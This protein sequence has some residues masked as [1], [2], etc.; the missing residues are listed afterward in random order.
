MVEIFVT[1]FLVVIA[2][3][4]LV[5]I[6]T[7]GEVFEGLRSRLEKL[8]G[9]LGWYAG[10]LSRCGYCFSVWASM[11]AALVVPG[12]ILAGGAW[13]MVGGDLVLKV[14]ILHRLSNL[15]HKAT[16]RWFEMVP[17]ILFLRPHSDDDP[18]VPGVPPPPPPGAEG[19]EELPRHK[20]DGGVKLGE[21][22]TADGRE[23]Q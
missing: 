22:E 2:I 18:T 21:E 20:E 19:V 13:W 5:E 9:R 17:F 12:K 16:W 15:W 23:E 10:G 1:W 7:E 3:E 8:P 14:L 6:V 11:P 4:A